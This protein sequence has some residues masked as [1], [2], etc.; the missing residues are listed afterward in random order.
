MSR[1]S[2]PTTFSRPGA[3]W[4]RA[5]QRS[6]KLEPGGRGAR[7]KA[8]RRIRTTGA[9]RSSGGSGSGHRRLQEEACRRKAGS[10]D[11]QGGA[12]AALNI[13]GAALPELVTGSADLTPSNNTKFANEVEIQ[14]DNFAGRYI[15]WGI[16]EHGMIA[17]CNG[18]SIHG[19]FIPSG[20]SFFCFTDYC[21]PSLRL[22]ALMGIRVVNVF[23]HDSIGL[24]E[25]GPTHQPVEHLASLRAMPNFYIWRPADRHRDRR[26]LAGG[27]RTRALALDPGADPPVHAG[28]AAD[29]CGGKPC[30]RAAATKVSP[31]SGEAQVSIFASGSEVSLA[32][33][34]QAQL[35][36][37]GVAARVVSMPCFPASSSSRRTIAALSSALR[38]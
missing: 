35:K 29:P 23:T 38:R 4:D 19:G 12:K 26:V 36:E 33:A 3:Q 31:A 16:R 18:I 28:G 8:A 27:A 10:R 1:S 20:A 5:A 24:G 15:H 17:A 34:A 11:P 25:D 14:A 6:G 22:S 32:V 7:R 13:I 37:K 21:R 2:S 30:A 9:R